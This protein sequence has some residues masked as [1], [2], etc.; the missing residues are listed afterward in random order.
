MNTPLATIRPDTLAHLSGFLGSVAQYCRAR[1]ALVGLEGKTAGLRYGI[2][3][4]L[5]AGGLFVGVLAYVFLVITAVFGVAAAWDW[6]HAWI[7]VLGIAALLH[8]AGAVALIFVAW[9][10]IKR[11]A[12]EV[13]LREFKKDQEWLS[14]WTKNN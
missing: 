11:G 12:F 5:V 2:A 7:V 13:T 9:R 10:E 3:L 14:Q 4:A 6:R 8:L 1:L